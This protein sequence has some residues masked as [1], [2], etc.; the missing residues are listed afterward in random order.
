VNSGSPR[1]IHQVD[2][3]GTEPDLSPEHVMQLEGAAAAEPEDLRLVVGRLGH[4]VG[5]IEPQGPERRIPDQAGA[6]RRPDYL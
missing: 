3:I 5:E 1:K 4:R 2:A 6:D